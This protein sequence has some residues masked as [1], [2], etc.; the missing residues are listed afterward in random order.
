MNKFFQTR[1]AK[2]PTS[3]STVDS[4]FSWSDCICFASE[5]GACGSKII[6]FRLQ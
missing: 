2:I 6:H 4:S 1:P 3:E 5:H